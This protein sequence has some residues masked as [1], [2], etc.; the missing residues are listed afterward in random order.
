MWA[1]FAA[2]IAFSQTEQPAT[3][4]V[5]H[6]EDK[7]LDKQQKFYE[8]WKAK[9]AKHKW[10]DE[11]F[12]VLFDAPTAT[13]PQLIADKSIALSFLPHE[14]KSIE[15][16]TFKIVRPFG[17]VSNGLPTDSTNNRLERWGNRIHMSTKENH[18]RRLLSFTEGEKL[19]IK[20]LEDN[21]EMLRALSYVDQIYMN[22]IE[23]SQN[24]IAINFLVKER[25]SWS[26]SYQAHDLNAHK[27]KIYNK[28][29]W[30]RGH[31][32]QIAYFYS[33]QKRVVNSIDFRYTIPSIGKSLISTTTTLEHNNS[34]DKYGLEF[35][36]A[37]I[38][39]KTQHAG[40]IKINILKKADRVPTNPIASF[41]NSINYHEIDIW[42]GTTL[43]Y[44]LQVNDKYARYRRALT[45]RIYRI[46][47]TKHPQIKADS[48]VFLLKT[49][50]ALLAYN[51]SKKQLYRSN[52][53]YNYGKVEN[54]PYGHLAQL[55]LGTVFNERQRKGYAGGNFERSYYNQR[56]DTYFSVRLSGGTFF[57]RDRFLDGLISFES[58]Y[59]SRLYRFRNIEHRHFF[60]LRYVIGFNPSDD[61]LHLNEEDGLRNFKSEEAKGDQKIVLNVE[62]VFFAPCTIAG[63]RSAFYSFADLAYICR[64]RSFSNNTNHF[65]A[66]IGL[67]I[68]LH[69]NNFIFKTFQL[70]FSLFLKAPQDVNF[71][72]PDA[73]SVRNERFRDFQIEK[74]YFYFERETYR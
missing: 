29:L 24:S 35:N 61:F 11:L 49:T 13:T 33:P 48:N 66:G 56:N 8:R 59:I 44:N 9:A 3:D 47:F 38:D 27:L 40:G 6:F 54:I 37:F 64:N 42:A 18:L 52:L 25:F 21:E 15:K 69:N 50:G 45:G 46:H 71:F 30:G 17:E 16:I 12:K 31:Y 57:N 39:Y 58:R 55:F 32:A 2:N 26:A 14:G 67:G 62:D 73:S 28:N 53:M 10:T 63:F 36:R 51:I 41:P 72:R 43:P 70:S 5:Y 19:D 20:Q 74:P 1:L 23:L 68:R 22:I 7:S 34:H 65:C 60:K 4:T